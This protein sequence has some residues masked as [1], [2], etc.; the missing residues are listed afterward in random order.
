MKLKRAVM[1]EMPAL[2]DEDLLGRARAGDAQAFGTL[3]RRRQGGIYRFALQMSGCTAAADDITQEVFLALIRGG[4]AYEAGRG[5]LAGYLYGIARNQVLRHLQ[6]RRDQVAFGEG[7]EDVPTPGASTLDDLA[8]QQRI[9]SVRQA[10]LALPPLY[11]EV[12]VL[13]DLQ[14]MEYAA[15]AQVVGCAVGTIR[16]RLHRG[17]ALLLE[18]LQRGGARAER[19]A[20]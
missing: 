10:V 3:Y 9:E 8:R 12:V 17:R 5:P 20:V 18:K 2:S 1:F 16:S 13:C 15:A 11:R 4:C 7:E 6:R 14:E 19:C